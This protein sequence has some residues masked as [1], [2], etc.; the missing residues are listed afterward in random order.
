MWLGATNGGTWPEG[1]LSEMIE[2]NIIHLHKDEDSHKSNKKMTQRKLRVQTTMQGLV[3]PQNCHYQACS[4]VH[5]W[6]VGENQ[7]LE[8]QVRR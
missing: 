2:N 5:L 7:A 1:D 6:E 8:T 4:R 3:A